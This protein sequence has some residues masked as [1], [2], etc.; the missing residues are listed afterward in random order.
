[1]PRMFIVFLIGVTGLAAALPAYGLL[2][3]GLQEAEELLAQG[4]YA[5]AMARYRE[6][7]IDFPDEP[8][9]QLGIGCAEFANAESAANAGEVGPASEKYLDARSAFE[10]VLESAEG[11]VWQAAAYNRA[12]SMARMALLLPEEEQWQPKVSALEEAIEAYEQLQRD[13]PEHAGIAQ[14]L[15]HSRLALM[16]LLQNPPPDE[17]P[18]PETSEQ[19]SPPPPPAVIQVFTHADTEIPRARARIVEGQPTV[20]LIAPEQAGGGS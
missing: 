10:R 7:Q 4:D 5:A 3:G 1:M 16:E 20:E 19:D 9:V 14:N 13:F 12:N 2:R 8:E 6:L 15:D 11:K 17:E 18:P